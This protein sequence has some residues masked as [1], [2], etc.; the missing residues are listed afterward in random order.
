MNTRDAIVV[1]Q[2]QL[3]HRNLPTAAIGGL[4][5]VLV[6]VVVFWGVVAQ[7]YLV[8]WFAGALLLTAYRMGVWRGFRRRQFTLE[9]S[10]KW[11]RH[12]VIGAGTSGAL[13]GAG[14]L[15]L[16]PPGQIA[17]QLIFLWAVSMMAVAGMFSY[18][19]HYPTYIAFF[20]PSTVPAVLGMAVQGTLSHAGFAAGM[21][22]Y[23]VVVFR[24][25]VTYHKM[26]IETQRLR[27]ENLELVGRVTEQMESAKSANLAK[28]R[29][30]AAASHDLRQPMHALNL[31]L[32][33]L[34]GLDLSPSAR[35]ML[36]NVSQCAQTMDEMFRALLDISRLDAGAVQPEPRDFPI[37]PMLERIRLEF[38]PQVRAKGLAL[39]VARSSAWIRS[40]PAFVERIVRNFIANAV[41]YTARG[42]VLIGCRRRAGAL[43]IA[44]H[45]TG[46]GIAPEEQRHVFEEFYQTNNPERDR[47]KGIGLGLAIV[48]RLALLMKGPVTLVSQPGRGSMFAVDLP[49]A[50]PE[51]A[52]AHPPAGLPRGS[53]AGSLVIVID[54]EEMILDATR[55]L[56]EQWEC[57]V[58][59]AVSG[60][61]AMEKL[62]TSPRAPDAIVCDYRLR[63]GENGM[64][65]IDALRAEFNGDIPALL[66]TGDTGPEHLR[67]IQASGLSVLHKP[68]QDKALREALGRLLGVEPALA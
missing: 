13:W 48:D 53:I 26:F 31:Y 45:D 68:V 8:A 55:S 42:K 58:V 22:I 65:V 20:I 37:G 63:G 39:R 11:L 34:A 52:A 10:R 49:L 41:R 56:L 6:V 54:D 43:R 17:Y 25:V 40:D 50:A 32:G 14:A 38:E 35:S 57:T 4:F 51:A 12:A 59:A 30:L 66:I 61:S 64:H 1:E 9:V 15:F 3:V 2:A 67:E 5:V 24:F 28:S 16:F 18:S 23:I 60:R 19:A 27:F 46:P 36:G 33:G 62:S 7:K 44:V 29:F 47:T 21:A